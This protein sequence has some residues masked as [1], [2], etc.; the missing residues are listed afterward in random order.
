MSRDELHEHLFQD[1]KYALV[2]CPNEGCNIRIIHKNE[3]REHY[4]KDCNAAKA[5]CTQCEGTFIVKDAQHHSCLE[6]LQTQC[7]SLNERLEEA[8]KVNK[9]LAGP[10]KFDDDYCEVPM[11]LI[12]EIMKQNVRRRYTKGSRTNRYCDGV[13][14]DA[15]G[16][17]YCA[18]HS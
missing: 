14:I 10:L 4:F 6:E 18:R 5:S 12:K 11:K 2:E 16:K 13:F 9:Q 8:K 15:V 7:F 3:I 1:C 17:I